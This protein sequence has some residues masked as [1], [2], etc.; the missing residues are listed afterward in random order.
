[1]LLHTIKHLA[2]GISGENVERWTT[3]VARKHLVSQKREKIKN[4]NYACTA[5]AHKINTQKL[6]SML[7]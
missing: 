2:M 5:Q 1:M 3:R 7:V 6:L 4:K